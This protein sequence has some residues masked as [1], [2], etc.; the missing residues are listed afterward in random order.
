MGMADTVYN[1]RNLV[2][3]REAGGG[4]FE[5]QVPSLTIRA[6]EVVVVRGASGCGKSTLLDLLA[7]A[8]EPDAMEV[9]RFRPHKRVSDDIGQLWRS[10]QLDALGRLRGTYIGYILQ[11]GGLL[12]F[13]SARENIELPARLHN[14]LSEDRVARLARQLGI[15]QELEKKPFQ[16]SVGQRQRVAIARA[17]AHKPAVVLAD[18]PTA[19]LDP[20]NA[21]T[22]LDMFL[23]LVRGS[24][25]A[26][27]IASHDWE[28]DP[29]ENVR[30]LEHRV[31]RMPGMTRTTFWTPSNR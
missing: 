19:S 8:L 15:A 29:V 9:F 12:S 28:P 17:L 3:R 4:R 13:L 10:G 30:M 20:G 25:I 27:I 18:E 22:I 31:E 14:C 6:G 26:A 16:L 11:T 23:A 21:Q 2:K 24:S 1:I 7:F 5:L